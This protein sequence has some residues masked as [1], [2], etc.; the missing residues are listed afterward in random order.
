LR[1]LHSGDRDGHR[2]QKYGFHF[3]AIG[4]VGTG[5]VTGF[6]QTPHELPG[7]LQCAQYVQFLH[8]LQGVAPT[9]V[10]TG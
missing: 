1:A 10:A 5:A 6:L 9:H 8:A 4:G 2:Q 7:F 3:L